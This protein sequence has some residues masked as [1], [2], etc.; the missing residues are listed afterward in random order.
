M[1]EAVDGIGGVSL[2]INEYDR[3]CIGDCEGFCT[4]ENCTV[5][6]NY[7]S[8]G[9]VGGTVDGPMVTPRPTPAVSRVKAAPIIEKKVDG[10]EVV[11]ADG[12]LGEDKVGVDR[13]QGDSRV[14]AESEVKTKGEDD[15][16]VKKAIMED[17]L[18]WRRRWWRRRVAGRVQGRPLV[19]SW[20]A[21]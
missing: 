17:K 1:R 21:D 10:N 19:A 2:E 8:G 11:G 3:R 5:K 6:C 18:M 20:A 7:T 9:S 16:D 12:A 13:V 14:E 15:A 4:A